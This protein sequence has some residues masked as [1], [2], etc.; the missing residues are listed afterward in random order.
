[1]RRKTPLQTRIPSRNNVSLKFVQIWTS[2][3]PF[4]SM[5]VVVMEL[6]VSFL[7]ILMMLLALKFSMSIRG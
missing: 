6:I 1:M 4:S 5:R 2:V 7:V 3:L